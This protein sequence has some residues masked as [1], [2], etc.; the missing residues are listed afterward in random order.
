[1]LGAAPNITDYTTFLYNV[2]DIPV[3]NLP[4]TAPIIATS[5]QIAQ[6]IVSFAIL[7]ASADLY[8]LAVYN[9]AADRL[10]NYAPDVSGQTWF[11]DTRK[12][13][14]LL[15]L[16]VGV[17]TSVSDGGTSVGV[18]NPEALKNLTLANLQLLK[19]PYGRQYLEIAQSWGTIWG[20]S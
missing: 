2:V 15:E 17:P 11:R 5:L 4:D 8:T 10:L 7:R 3:A 18:L 12:K 20:V 13:M 16:S 1:M 19:T 6:D 14:R 9:L